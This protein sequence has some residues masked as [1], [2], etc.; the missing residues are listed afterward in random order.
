MRHD[1]RGESRHQPQSP[2]VAAIRRCYERHNRGDQSAWAEVFD[3]DIE[4]YTDGTRF[5]EETVQHGKQATLR[6]FAD[7]F[8]AFREYEFIVGDIFEIGSWVVAEVPVRAVGR[9]SGIEVGQSGVGCYRFA[10]D[11]VVE[12]RAFGE[13]DDALRAIHGPVP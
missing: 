8:Q 2:R 5:A 10:G 9:S 4:F 13:L 7:Y 6:W 1:D 12:F 11:R 3:N